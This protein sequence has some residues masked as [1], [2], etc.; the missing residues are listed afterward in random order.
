M[1]NDPRLQAKAAQLE[2]WHADLRG[3]RTIEVPELAG[4][5]VHYRRNFRRLSSYCLI[6]ACLN[7]LMVDPR[8]PFWWGSLISAG[9]GAWTMV[10]AEAKALAIGRQLNRR[11]SEQV[12][13]DLLGYHW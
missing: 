7:T 9:L 6:L 8:F 13:R 4:F 3:K 12:A 2:Q 5:R 10:F 1:T 11:A